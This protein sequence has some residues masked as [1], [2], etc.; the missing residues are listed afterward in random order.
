MGIASDVRIVVGA[1]LAL[2]LGYIYLYI[3]GQYQRILQDYQKTKEALAKIKEDAELV[4]SGELDRVRKVQILASYKTSVYTAWR[5]TRGMRRN[6][7]SML[8]LGKNLVTLKHIDEALARI[9][10]DFGIADGVVREETL[11][12]G[13]DLE[14]NEKLVAAIYNDPIIETMAISFT[15]DGEVEQDIKLRLGRSFDD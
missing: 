9:C 8:L 11:T 7:K 5:F 10:N 14:G 2:I 12:S 13:L 3:S 15:F 1:L 4:L 6:W